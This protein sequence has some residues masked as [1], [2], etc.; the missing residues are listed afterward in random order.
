MIYDLEDKQNAFVQAT[1]LCALFAMHNDF[2]V[3]DVY[4]NPRLFHLGVCYHRDS[5]VEVNVGKC[6]NPCFSGRAWSFPG[7]TADR[8]V[9]GVVAHEFGHVWHFSKNKR[10]ITKSFKDNVWF[11]ELAVTGYGETCI[12]EAIAE[13]VKLYITNPML[14]VLAYPLHAA[15]LHSHGLM[16]IVKTPWDKILESSPRHVKAASNKIRKAQRYANT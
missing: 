8:T 10:Q 3:P 15:W 4:E 7:Y 2:P 12:H 16:P 9:L 5:S 1:N 14:L 13:A 11:E 6:P